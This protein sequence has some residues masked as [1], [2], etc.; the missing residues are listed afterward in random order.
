MLFWIT[1]IA[2][3]LIVALLLGLA[4]LRG[5]TGSEP[6]A[7]YDLRVYR[8]QLK[9]VDKDLARGVIEEADAERVRAEISR[10]ILAADAQL[11]E[12]G[13]TGGQPA[14]AG[15][16]VAVLMALFVIAGGLGLY[17][18]L[19][20]PGFEDAPLQAR[21]DAAK[22]KHDSRPVQAA[23]EA[24]LPVTPG[25]TPD[26]EYAELIEKLRASVAERPDDLQGQILLARNEANLGNLKAAYEAQAAVLRIK[27][28]EAN[29][30]DYLTHAQLLISAAEGYVS[31]E[32]E[33]S[34]RR[35]ME[36]DPRNPLARYYWGLMLLQNDR[37][38]RTFRLWE[39]LLRD[40]THDAPWVPPIRQSLPELAWFAGVDYQLPPA[41][42]TGGPT[43]E[44][45]QA[46]SEMSAEEQSE[47][48]R[49]MVSSLAERL[50]TEGGTPQE[51]ARLIGAYGVLG[52]Q[53]RAIAIWNE[54]QDVFAANEEAL[55]IVRGGAVQA[56][57]A[58]E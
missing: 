43:A 31:P 35:V 42:P 7:A 45:M 49:G 40:S 13:D 56:G 18:S 52:E 29:I 1:A 12:G 14:G 44:D 58:S 34:L 16:V 28:D 53:D 4:I 32:A 8:D 21:I 48:I 57:I 19:G 17:S 24:T 54:A 20:Q 9:E 26:G 51:W 2:L 39:Q 47:M 6:P 55:A 10:R 23:F 11:K 30:D 50:N 5:R 33:A 36:R 3:T 27:G 37:P 22:A 15:R 46:A 38:D 25:Q 41:A